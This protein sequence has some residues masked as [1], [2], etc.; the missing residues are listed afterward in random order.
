MS[1]E[2]LEITLL[3]SIVFYSVILFLLYLMKQNKML[4]M[5]WSLLFIK[6]ILHIILY[7][8]SFLYIYQA[9][10][11]IVNELGFDIFTHLFPITEESS[12]CFFFLYLGKTM[13]EQSIPLIMFIEVCFSYEVYRKIGKGEEEKMFRINYIMIGGIIIFLNL[14]IIDAFLVICV[15]MLFNNY[16]MGILTVIKIIREKDFNLNGNKF[17]FV[18][19]FIGQFTMYNLF[20]IFWILYYINPTVD[21]IN[22]WFS[23]FSIVFNCICV[24]TQYYML[25]RYSLDIENIRE[26]EDVQKETMIERKSTQKIKRRLS[27]TD[28]KAVTIYVR[29]KIQQL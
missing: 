18:L 28:I 14:F 20:I 5:I 19:V 1:E 6:T 25:M 26:K 9:V 4:S 13:I 16:I 10:G 21:F 15:I 12:I 24:F 27:D 11:D 22:D 3:L 2:Q 8:E 23:C 29:S 7:F 17:T